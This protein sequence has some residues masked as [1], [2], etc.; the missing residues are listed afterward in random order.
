MEE[1]PEYVPPSYL[2]ALT[3]LQSLTLQSPRD[4]LRAAVESLTAL[5]RLKLG[6]VPAGLDW[7][8]QWLPMLQDL[9]VCC[10]VPAVPEGGGAVVP[11]TITMDSLAGLQRLSLILISVD[12]SGLATWGAEDAPRGGLDALGLPPNLTSLSLYAR[13]L[14]VSRVTG[15][16]SLQEMHAEGL[17]DEAVWC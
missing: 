6:R 5:T 16:N 17:T 10:D 7:T 2:A 9:A 11:P 4:S 3:S 8:G 1:H 15:A 12:V 14:P 13:G